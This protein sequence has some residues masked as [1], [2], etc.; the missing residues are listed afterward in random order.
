VSKLSPGDSG[1]P[2]GVI[3][4]NSPQV[5]ARDVSKLLFFHCLLW[6]LI[7]VVLKHY[8]I[9]LKLLGFDVRISSSSRENETNRFIGE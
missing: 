8:E 2:Y 1:N 4:E 9:V 3:S 6:K 5:V 7:A